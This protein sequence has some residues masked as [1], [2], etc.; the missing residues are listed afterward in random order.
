MTLAA[1]LAAL[2]VAPV[3]LLLNRWGE[4]R[5]A[6]RS[7]AGRTA[8]AL[9]A[10][11]WVLVAVLTPLVAGAVVKGA[12]V[13]TGASTPLFAQIW[14]LLWKAA[15]FGALVESAARALLSARWPAWRVAPI[16]D[17]AARRLAPYP[18]LIAVSAA[19]AGFL[20]S[21]NN[22]LGASSATSEAVGC[23]T[24]LLELAV[25]ASALG[26][27][28][29][30]RVAEAEAASTA[31]DSANVQLPWILAAIAA[32]LALA[33]AG[34]AMVAGYLAL[35]TFVMRE[36]VW[37]AAVL[38]ALFILM[39]G[40]DTAVAWLLSPNRPLGRAIRISI[41][42]STLGVEQVVELVSGLVR[43]A[44]LL[45]AW[46]A[47]LAPFGADAQDV[48]GRITS[49]DLV[50]RLGQVSISPGAIAG[51]L[52]VLGIG[53]AAT[54]VLRVWL[55]SRYLPKTRMDLGVRT[56]LAS[57]VTYVGVF[58]AFLLTC[59]YLGLSLDRIALFASA[60]SV[61]IGF[62]LQ[63]IIGNFV[64]GLILLAERPIKVGD[65]IAIGDMEG[66]VRRI[67]VR[68]T[69]VEMGDHS[70]LIVPNSELVSKI[71]RNV[72]HGAALGRVK[73]VLSLDARSDPLVVRDLLMQR[74][75]VH[76]DALSDPAAA[77]YM[78]DIKDGA[79]EFT[80]FVYLASPREAFKAK[81]DLLFQ[82]LPDLK[83]HG[84]A[85]ATSNPV[86][87]VDVGDRP[88]E[89]SGATA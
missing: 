51:A 10:V 52:L 48:F 38:A 87:H 16:S 82:I 59:A 33:C 31:A 76:P 7:A 35:A 58:A 15:V 79:M 72:T 29:R 55:E 67:N 56:S 2:L 17:V 40:V 21:L 23:L 26:Q 86:V 20:A 8:A 64:S 14:S 36:F 83:A 4:V 47:I 27:I 50:L 30:A 75:Q 32:W 25:I 63:A 81:S 12:L 6:K 18:V 71:V 73:I 24:L 28:G 74:L 11:W 13:D 49:T 39:R 66:D 53:L 19:L 42:L 85:L 77:V 88:M 34:V 89:P 44:L 5:L 3:R 62:G 60:L 57:G 78:T 70:R 46:A 43:L 41:G 80:A 54:Q 61:G 68:A 45:A 65:W 37:A 84:I 22:L 1:L 9:I 69:E